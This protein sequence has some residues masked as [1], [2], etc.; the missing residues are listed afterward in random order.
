MIID[1]S[2]K[3][4]K[5]IRNIA[6]ESEWSGTQNPFCPARGKSQYEHSKCGDQHGNWHTNKVAKGDGQTESL[7]LLRSHVVQC[8][9]IDRAKY[10]ENGKQEEVEW[11]L[12]PDAH[13]S[14]DIERSSTVDINRFNV[15]EDD[16]PSKG[17]N[18]HSDSLVI[19]ETLFDLVHGVE[20]VLSDLVS[21]GQSWQV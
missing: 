17:W 7:I 12:N 10:A 14:K 2:V 18:M 11:N 4:V 6:K 13:F 21:I 20:T 16:T 9:D 5:T 3:Q 1:N 8:L 15:S 19:E